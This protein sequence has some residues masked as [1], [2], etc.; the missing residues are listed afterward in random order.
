MLKH[1]QATAN[2]HRRSKRSLHG[3][4]ASLNGSTSSS[5]ASSTGSVNCSFAGSETSASSSFVLGNP[6]NNSPVHHLQSSLSS[7]PVTPVTGNPGNNNSRR[8]SSGLTSLT[9]TTTIGD[10]RRSSYSSPEPLSMASRTSSY[11]SLST[12]DG[13]VQGTGPRTTVKIYAKCL[14][15]DIEYKTLSVSRS[16]TSAEVIWMLLSK[17]KMRHRDPKLFYLTMDIG[18]AA[19]SRTLSLDEDSRPAELKSCHPW[20]DCKFTLQMKK[21]G[22]VRIH[23]SVL[24][25]E[26]KYK[27]LLIS[28][29][30]T[31]REVITILFHCYGLERIERVDRY[32]LCE[33]NAQNFERRLHPEDCPAIIQQGW[34]HDQNKPVQFVLK[35]NTVI[36]SSTQMSLSVSVASAS[37]VGSSGLSPASTASSSETNS[38][39]EEAM[40][41]SYSTS[42]NSDH[43]PS[44]SPE[45]TFQSL[46]GQN[47]VVSSSSG[48]RGSSGV[49]GSAA[50]RSLPGMSTSSNS[51]KPQFNIN[52]PVSTST[53]TG[54]L[55]RNVT[56]QQARSFHEVGL[57]PVLKPKRPQPQASLFLA[58]GSRGNITHFSNIRTKF[59]DYEN[60]FYI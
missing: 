32:V 20:G 38:S 48:L 13:L 42:S 17:Y 7:P 6:N 25:A 56:F 22:L 44:P 30:T 28:E 10:S 23:D 47:N 53:V 31:V 19:L 43:S 37:S 34:D 18:V 12:T 39:C 50:I 2:E 3:D 21:G 49:S 59:H 35:R 33:V 4:N 1:C 45:L 40:D 24:M 46:G 58:N 29:Q 8:I 51:T 36:P 15:S 57:P 5:S 14:R 52:G 27:C 9:S 16:T 26:S 55:P 11:A 41:T 54:T 60:Y